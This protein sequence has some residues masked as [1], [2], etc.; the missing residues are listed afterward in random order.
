MPK[1]DA[2][3]LL[4]EVELELMN[5]I[6][7][8]GGGTVNEVLSRLPKGRQLAYTTVST[9]LRILEQKKV[10]SSQKQGR[11]HFYSPLIKKKDYGAKSVKHIVQNVFDGAPLKLV[12]TLIDSK[13][14]SSDDIQQLQQMIEERLEK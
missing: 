7:E 6:W 2:N 9:M 11:G 13:N 10:L 4:T 1:K 12:K 5:I 3:K 14:L 8:L